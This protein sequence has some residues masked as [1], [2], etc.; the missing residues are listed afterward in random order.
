MATKCYAAVRGSAVRVTGLGSRGSIPD[1]IQYATSKSLAKVTINEVTTDGSDDILGSEDND[2]DQRVRLIRP[3][4]TINYTV[5]IDFLRVDPGVLN[6]V[7]GVP[8]VRKTHGVGFGRALFGEEPFGGGPTPTASGLGFGEDTFGEE[9]FGGDFTGLGFGFGEDEFGEAA[10]GQG[11]N[12][13]IPEEVEEMI[14]VGFDSTTRLTPVSFALEVWSKLAGAACVDG[15]EYGYTVFPYLKGG[16]L[17]GFEF[18]NG[19][20]SFNLRGAQT[21]RSSRWGRGPHDL[22]GPYQRLVG[23]VSGNTFFRQTLTK[24]L[25]PMEVNGIQETEDVI[26]GGT[27]SVTSPDIISGG[28]AAS[29][30]PW[31]VE[32]GKAV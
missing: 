32:G 11:T 31:V 16:R 12:E 30:S 2:N 23:P 6:L 29:T 19:L 21:R 15:K 26:H 17:T 5:D 25:P 3:T 27:A 7:A 1:L 18:K 13:D 28:N 24:A 4:Q 22:E 8:M 10:F 14:V 9:T 20:V